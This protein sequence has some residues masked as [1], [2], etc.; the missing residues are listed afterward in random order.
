MNA[1]H[2][3]TS[4]TD[5]LHEDEGQQTDQVLAEARMV[6]PGLLS[7][8]GLRIEQHQKGETDYC[9]LASP[10]LAAIGGGAL[11]HLRHRNPHK[12]CHR[13]ARA[14]PYPSSFPFLRLV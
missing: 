12:P 7:L 2:D 11:R 3:V 4:R 8:L 13:G 6:L 14:L 5:D 10:E 1:G 9:P